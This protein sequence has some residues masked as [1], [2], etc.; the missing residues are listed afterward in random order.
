MLDK[1]LQAAIDTTNR[2]LKNF[3]KF[4]KPLDKR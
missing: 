1:L 2:E 4:K 3:K